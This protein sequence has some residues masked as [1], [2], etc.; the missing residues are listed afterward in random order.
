MP[1]CVRR[2][3]Y[4]LGALLASAATAVIIG[5]MLVPPPAGARGGS[6]S[7]PTTTTSATRTSTTA[8]PAT[9]TT[10]A[11]PSATTSTTAQPATT[12]TTA[13]P[14]TTTRP[15]ASPT[16]TTTTPGANSPDAVS[17]PSDSDCQN[18]APLGLSGSWTCTFDDEFADDASLNSVWT[19][20]LTANS[21][22]TAGADCYVDN[23]DTVS[24]SGGTLNLSVV[25]VAPFTCDS[26]SGDFTSDYEAG[27]VSTWQRFDQTYGA[28]EVDAKLP[29]A[30]VSGLQETFWLYPQTLSYGSWPDSGE[31]DFAEFYSQ[32]WGD[33]VP[34][35]HYADSSSD[36]D[37]T[38]Y[39]C[40]LNQDTFNTYEVDW[41]PG[42]LTVLYNGQVCLVDHPLTGQEPFNQPFFMALTQALGMGSNA[43][44]ASTPASATTQVAW[45]RAWQQSS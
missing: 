9:T 22:Y 1:E 3:R 39:D 17:A 20:Q 11:R 26:P 43:P 7:P 31:I 14:T 37:V 21:G 33:D 42:V 41:Q 34:Y 44:T 23:P 10:T 27:M 24:V 32:Y 45:V 28:F 19:P 2:R 4:R 25:K 35:I 12:T 30:T 40:T 29:A 15:P 5:V 13:R 38:A 16:T 36:P 18:T 6:A 8:R